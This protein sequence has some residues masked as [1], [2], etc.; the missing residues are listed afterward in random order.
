MSRLDRATATRRLL[1]MLARKGYSGGMAAAVVREA[2]DARGDEEE[3]ADL[4]DLDEDAPVPSG[5]STAASA[6]NP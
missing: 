5:W 2:L 3:G 1:G 6:D 4:L